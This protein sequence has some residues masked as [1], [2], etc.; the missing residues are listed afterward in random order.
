MFRARGLSAGQDQTKPCSLD[1]HNCM[2]SKV[3]VLEPSTLTEGLADL[4]RQRLLCDVW[5]RATGQTELSGAVPAH[6][7]HPATPSANSNSRDDVPAHAVVLA[8]TCDYFRALLAGAGAHMR[9]TCSGN[10]RAL[11]TELQGS[12]GL[13]GRPP[14]VH[15][16]YTSIASSVCHGLLVFKGSGGSHATSGRS[17]GLVHTVNGGNAAHSFLTAMHYIVQEAVPDLARAWCAS[18]A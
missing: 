15:S 16:Q 5:L 7:E 17:R 18:P 8:A 11:Q 12:K 10:V 3:L 6:D 4:W 14:E 2:Q 13:L 1:V 9:D